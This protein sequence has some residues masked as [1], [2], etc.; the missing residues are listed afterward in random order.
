M[1]VILVQRFEPVVV[2]EPQEWLVGHF[3]QLRIRR[4]AVTDGVPA[5]RSERVATLP[6]KVLAADNAF[7]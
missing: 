5:R 3:E 6:F 2:R 4:G 7:A 1:S